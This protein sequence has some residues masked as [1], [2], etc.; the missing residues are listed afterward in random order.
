MLTKIWAELPKIQQL[1]QDLRQE[2]TVC[3]FWLLTCASFL[4]KDLSRFLS[5]GVLKRMDQGVE[6]DTRLVTWARSKP[7]SIKKPR[8]E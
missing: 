5:V 1:H 4:I 8:Y 6:R 7:Y 2:A 3:V